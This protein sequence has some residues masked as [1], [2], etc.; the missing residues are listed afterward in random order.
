MLKL[1]HAINKFH[2]QIR[3]L[4]SLAGGKKEPSQQREMAVDL[5]KFLHFAS[6]SSLNLQNV[7]RMK[8]VDEYVEELRR[9]KVGPSGIISK[10]NNLC[11]TQTFVLH[12]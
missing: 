11:H 7:V 8:A 1:Y 12:R 5:S 4:G 10:L 9:R 6:S 3:F 2:S